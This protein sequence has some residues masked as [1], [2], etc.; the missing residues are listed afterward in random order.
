MLAKI[1]CILSQGENLTPLFT[2][3]KKF[4]LEARELGHF[5]ERVQKVKENRRLTMLFSKFKFLQ[6]DDQDSSNTPA[7]QVTVKTP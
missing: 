2:E 4:S 1:D 5:V 3:L 7:N 6:E